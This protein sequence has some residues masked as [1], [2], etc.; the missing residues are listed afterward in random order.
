MGRIFKPWY[1]RP[2]GAGGK[3]R[4]YLKAWYV[5]YV[6][7]N[8]ARQRVSFTISADWKEVR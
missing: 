8:D 6:D 1:T 5:D 7:E 4:V 2:D 3:V